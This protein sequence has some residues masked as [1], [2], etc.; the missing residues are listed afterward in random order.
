VL[1]AFSM[2]C[3]DS[4]TSLTQVTWSRH[5]KHPP[6]KKFTRLRSSEHEDHGMGPPT[7]THFS[8]KT[9]ARC[10]VTTR[11]WAGAPSRMNSMWVCIHRETSSMSSGRIFIK[12]IVIRCSWEST[13]KNIW[14]H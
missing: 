8:P 6:E 3:C 9:G 10:C 1:Q 13:W 14:S 2:P 4:A 11:K 12:K 7:T 5:F